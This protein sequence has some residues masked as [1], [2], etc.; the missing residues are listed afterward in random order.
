MSY[1]IAEVWID[2]S[3]DEQQAIL[4]TIEEEYFELEQ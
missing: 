1:E 2:L 3:Y 4:E